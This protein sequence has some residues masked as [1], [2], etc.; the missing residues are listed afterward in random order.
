MVGAQAE[1]S[2]KHAAQTELF[3]HIMS[4]VD[5]RGPGWAPTT[6]NKQGAA[7]RGGAGSILS[8]TQYWAVQGVRCYGCST[9]VYYSALGFKVVRA[10]EPV[11]GPSPPSPPLV[12]PGVTPPARCGSS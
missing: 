11:L 3:Q 9:V 1:D 10:R 7:G 4:G 12:R 2:E 5:A 8:T 6:K